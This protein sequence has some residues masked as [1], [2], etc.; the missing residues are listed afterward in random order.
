MGK[1]KELRYFIGTHGKILGWIFINRPEDKEDNTDITLYSQLDFKTR[2]IG[3]IFVQEVS[4]D[5]YKRVYSHTDKDIRTFEACL[6]VETYKGT[7]IN[8]EL[9][10]Q[11]FL[12]WHDISFEAHGMIR[13]LDERIDV[14]LLKKGFVEQRAMQTEETFK[15]EHIACF[16]GAMEEVFLLEDTFIGEHITS[17][18]GAMEEVF[19]L[20]SYNPPINLEEIFA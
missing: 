10:K 6:L 9:G 11:L 20:K 8:Y 14:P 12:N 7:N 18:D 17:F 3:K 15:G 1:T 4:T 19:T 13:L 16:Y 2:K 5:E